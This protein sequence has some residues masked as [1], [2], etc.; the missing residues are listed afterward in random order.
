MSGCVYAAAA[1]TLALAA[2]ALAPFLLLAGG[3]ALFG[4]LLRKAAC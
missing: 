4:R 2:P 3:V 1:V